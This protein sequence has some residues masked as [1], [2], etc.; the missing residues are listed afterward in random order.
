MGLQPQRV[1][2]STACYG[3]FTL[4]R[5][6]SPGFG[7]TPRDSS[8]LFGLAFAP[9]PPQK[10]LAS[11]RRVTRRLILQ[12]ARGQAFQAPEAEASGDLA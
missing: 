2:A 7:S 11:P 8:A 3:R 12:K 9:A 10:G 6:R 5:G 4:A 1:R